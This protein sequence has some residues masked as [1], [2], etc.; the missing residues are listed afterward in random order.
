[1]CA[2]VRARGSAVRYRDRL[3]FPALFFPTLTRWD[4]RSIGATL[5]NSSI[6]RRSTMRREVNAIH[7]EQLPQRQRALSSTFSPGCC[8]LNHSI[9]SRPWLPGTTCMPTGDVFMWASILCSAP[10][11]KRRDDRQASGYHTTLANSLTH[12]TTII[13]SLPY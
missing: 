13:S 2:C 6:S 4:I 3:F 12:I 8:T 10:K 11:S 5:N 9:N 7:L 1:M